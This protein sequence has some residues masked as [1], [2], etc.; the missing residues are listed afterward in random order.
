MPRKIKATKTVNPL[1]FE[2]LEPHRFEDL[3]RRLLYN[4]RDWSNIEATGRS[5]SDEGFD[6]R[7]WE[8]SDVID[9][10]NDEGDEGT[11]NLDGR[12]WQVQGKREKSITPA[13]MRALIREGVDRDNPPYGY[14]LAGATNISKAAYDVFRTELKLKGVSEFYFWGKDHLEDQLSLPQN[15]E[16]LFT[17]FGLSLIP[18]RRSRIAEI[19]FNINNKNK[20][21]KLIFGSDQFPHNGAPERGRGFLLRDVNAENYPYREAYPD[22]EQRR[23]WEEHDAVTVTPKGI[24]FK[25][26]ERYAYLNKPEMQWDFSMAVDLTPRIHNI[27]AANQARLDDLGPRAERFWRHLPRSFQAKRTTYGF[28]NFEEILI[29]DDKGDPEYAYPHVF[30]DFGTRGPFK[31]L[32]HN[33][34]QNREIVSEDEL[35][36]WTRAKI[37]PDEFPEPSRNLVQHEM[38]KLELKEDEVWGLEHIRGSSILYSFDGKLRELS[39]GNIIH[40]P[41]KEK[42]GSEKHVEVTHVYVTSVGA[43]AKTPGSEYH[44]LRLEHIAGREISDS[45]SVTV[46]EIQEVMLSFEKDRFSYIGGYD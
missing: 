34:Q 46:Y 15:D 41:T 39:E 20:M 42:H 29:I 14:I 26:R 44:R 5:G 23:R 6:V 36:G 7:A 27:D 32:I 12:M 38:E 28:L 37:L 24:Y 16:I 17:F 35:K 11:H 25:V 13:K 2:D 19:K 33:F 1:H 18:R 9:N 3:V 21:L 45:D 30:I 43:L 4:F 40:I 31:Y 10:T 8:A 22:F